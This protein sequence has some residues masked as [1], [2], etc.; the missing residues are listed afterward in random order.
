MPARTEGLSNKLYQ[1]I[2][3]VLL[4]EWDP[5][6]IQEEPLAQKEYDAYVPTLVALVAQRATE[7]EIFGHL[8]LIETRR[9]ELPGNRIHTGK[10][11]TRLFH[12]PLL[13]EIENSLEEILETGKAQ[14]C[15]S[16]M[17]TQWLARGYRSDEILPLLMELQRQFQTNGNQRAE[18]LVIE[19]MDWLEGRCMP[20]HSLSATRG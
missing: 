4:K 6:G 3:H 9:L 18:D 7:K 20:E 15:F 1:K 19:G 10:I 17:L 13:L 12:L 5:I 8:W 11:A 16:T 14:S 2:Q